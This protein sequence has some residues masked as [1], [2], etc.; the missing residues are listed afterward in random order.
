MSRCQAYG[1]GTECPPRPPAG[2]RHLAGAQ[3]PWVNDSSAPPQGQT[4]LREKYRQVVTFLYFPSELFC[5]EFCIR[6]AWVSPALVT[7]D[8]PFGPSISRPGPRVDSKLSPS[9]QMQGQTRKEGPLGSE[10][11]G[12]TCI[13]EPVGSPCRCGQGGHR[14]EALSCRPA[15]L[16]P[17]PDLHGPQDR[18]ATRNSP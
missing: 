12:P 8:L 10:T 1:G 17:M 11:P 3:Q 18:A 2:A 5:L 6:T 14:K 9:W 15:G 16:S 7:G 13:L 4:P